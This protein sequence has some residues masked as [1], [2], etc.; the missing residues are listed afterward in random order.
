MKKLL[1]LAWMMVLSIVATAQ[2]I[3]VIDKDGNRAPYDPDKITSIEFQA[4]PPGFTIYMDG[5]A[6]SYTFDVV[7]SMQG[8]PNFVFVDPQTVSVDADGVELAVQVKANA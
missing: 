4:T 1:L 5:Q 7:K 8:N 3:I 6:I 2:T